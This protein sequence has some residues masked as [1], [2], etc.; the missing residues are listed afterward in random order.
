MKE[1]E[2][3]CCTSSCDKTQDASY[4]ESQYK[5][6]KTGWD[7]GKVSP[8]IKAYID[9]VINKNVRILIP[10]CGNSYEAEYLIEKG[11]TN[12]TVIDIAPTL[13]AILQKKFKNNPKIQVILGDFFEHQG[14]YD[15]II[16]QTFFCALP[17]SMRQ[18]YVWKMNQLLA[19]NGILTGLLFDRFF[20]SG[21][22][23]GGSHTEYKQLFK[24]SFETIK[25]ETAN[26]SIAPRAN[27][28][29]FVELQKNN[30]VVVH[31]YDFEGINC[32]GFGD[33]VTEKLLGIEEVVH[34]SSNN[35][36]TELLLVSSNEIA[37][38]VLQQNISFD[39]KYTIQK[40]TL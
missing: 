40:T 12:I 1:K 17:T 38:E 3:E 20:E 25:M 19:K 4:W 21:P 7:I 39:R 11:F 24:D 29:L 26:N 5:A 28:E 34:V 31:L 37:V 23:F 22:P 15:L 36:Y 13:V 8:P 33:K 9:T 14:Q 2:L 35:N 30:K 6:K 18:K 32:S 27:S 10:G 16:E